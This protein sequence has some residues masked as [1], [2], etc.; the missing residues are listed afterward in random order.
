MTP[1]FRP[2]LDVLPGPQ[3]ALWPDL[4]QVPPYFALYGGTGLALHLGHR[5]SVD[6]D[7]FGTNNIDPDDLM[8]MLPSCKAQQ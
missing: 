7:F 8:A 3:L 1:A 2:R 6:F 5:V 4:S